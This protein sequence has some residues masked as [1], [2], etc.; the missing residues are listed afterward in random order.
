LFSASPSRVQGVEDFK[1]ELQD[2][3]HDAQFSYKVARARQAAYSSMRYRAHQYE[4]GNKV[5]INKTLFSD[6]YSQ[7]YDKLTAKRYGRLS[8]RNWWERMP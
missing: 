6:A 5:W 8:S 4:V 1:T 2:V 3:L 7:S